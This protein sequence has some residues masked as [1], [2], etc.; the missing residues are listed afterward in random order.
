MTL[1]NSQ[2]LHVRFENIKGGAHLEKHVNRK[3]EDVTNVSFHV[4]G[5]WRKR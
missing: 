4:P 3:D 1:E 5:R 2:E